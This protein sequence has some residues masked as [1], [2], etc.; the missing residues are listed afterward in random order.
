MLDLA[1]LSLVHVQQ[2]LGLPDFD[3]AAAQRR[4][5][6]T[7]RVPQAFPTSAAPKQAAVL[8]LLYEREAELHFVLTRRAE[9][10]G[11]H[12]G[13]ISFPGGRREAD[14]SYIQ[15]ALRETHEELGVL[16]E[17][18][19]VLG[20]LAQLY[21]PPSNYLVQPIVG[22][23]AAQPHWRPKHDEVAEVIEVPLRLLFDDTLKGAEETMRYGLPFRI[24]YYDLFGHKVWGATASI[25]SELEM[26]LRTALSNF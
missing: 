7:V 5:M 12:S 10:T 6:P 14:E 23:C 1:L 24:V 20:A 17:S 18:V 19:Q 4:M 21:I 2:A 22:T 13:Q 9:H 11:V 8:L 25:L 16:P 26:R 15:T 3:T